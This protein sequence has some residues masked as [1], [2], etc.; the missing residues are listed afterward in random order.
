MPVIPSRWGPEVDPRACDS[1][2]IYGTSD[3]KTLPRIVSKTVW[4][5]SKTVWGNAYFLLRQKLFLCHQ[6]P[7]Q[8]EALTH[9][10][11]CQGP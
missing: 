11:G 2:L 8:F 6:L 1:P 9:Q 10:A 7:G 5:N 4:G 3:T